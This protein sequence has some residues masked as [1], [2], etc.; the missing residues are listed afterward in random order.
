MT[1]N[2]MVHEHAEQQQLQPRLQDFSSNVDDPHCPIH[3]WRNI[4]Y[5]HPLGLTEKDGKQHDE[6]NAASD[7][8]LFFN[9][10]A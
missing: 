4:S 6:G 10:V 2:M 7:V 1:V 5:S 3:E 9:N 8:L